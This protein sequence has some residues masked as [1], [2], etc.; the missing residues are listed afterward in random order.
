[1]IFFFPPG[2]SASSASQT[3]VLIPQRS[4]IQRCGTF[5]SAASRLARRGVSRCVLQVVSLISELS[6]RC[7]TSGEEEEGWWVGVGKVGVGPVLTL[8]LMKPFRCLCRAR[9]G[10]TRR[11]SS[12]NRPCT[13]AVAGKSVFMRV[14]IQGGKRRKKKLYQSLNFSLCVPNLQLFSGG[15]F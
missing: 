15:E 14:S 9:A 13:F 4:L 12:E 5:H 6:Q 1:M 3:A 8:R 10:C 11:D 2:P 7:D